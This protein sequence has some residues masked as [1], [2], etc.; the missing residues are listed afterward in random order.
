MRDTT[1][2][3][4][5]LFWTLYG[6]NPDQ[7]NKI[8]AAVR[9]DMLDDAF[10]WYASNLTP[11]QLAEKQATGWTLEGAIANAKK[12][13]GMDEKEDAKN[14]YTDT[15]KTAGKNFVSGA[16]KSVTNL[17]ALLDGMGGDGDKE[18]GTWPRCKISGRVTKMA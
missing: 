8:P 1:K 2:L 18:T 14:N 4:P 5:Y 10:K 12:T 6:L 3:T 13:Y 9:R 17:G 7:A 16:T 11:E 15:I